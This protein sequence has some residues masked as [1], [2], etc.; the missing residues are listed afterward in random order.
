MVNKKLAQRRVWFPLERAIMHYGMI[1]K[2]PG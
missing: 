1:R 2:T